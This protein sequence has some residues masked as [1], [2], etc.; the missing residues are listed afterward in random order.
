M[1]RGSLNINRWHRLPAV[2]AVSGQSAFMSL[3]VKASRARSADCA[4]RAPRHVATACLQLLWRV[5]LQ[6]PVPR[7][8]AL[9]GHV[10]LWTKRPRG[11]VHGLALLIE[12]FVRVHPIARTGRGAVQ[13]SRMGHVPASTS[14]ATTSASLSRSS[15]RSARRR[16]RAAGA[17]R[18][19][20]RSCRTLGL[21]VLG[22]EAP[23]D[24][25]D[26]Q[27]DQRGDWRGF[28]NATRARSGERHPPKVVTTKNVNTN[29]RARNVLRFTCYELRV[30]N[31]A[32]AHRVA[33]GTP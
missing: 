32:Y 9:G 33:H 21:G 7:I 13:V 30:T 27:R 10:A 11:A 25:G 12:P 16:A 29:V 24:V 4:A 1:S 3:N 8:A 19:S 17:P 14:C 31:H 26:G 18:G 20:W 22:L 6:R 5:K 2:R 15:L 28:G 23:L